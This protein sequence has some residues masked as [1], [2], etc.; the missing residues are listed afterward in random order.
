MAKLISVDSMF[1]LLRSFTAVLDEFGVSNGRA[2]QA[3][4]CAGE[5]LL[6]VRLLE[7]AIKEDKE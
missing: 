2:K 1:A 3:V 4:L 5:G 6:V 7:L